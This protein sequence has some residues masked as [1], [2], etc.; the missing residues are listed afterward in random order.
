MKPYVI[1]H[2]MSSVDGHALTDGW[3]RTVKKQAD[4]TYERLAER[5]D[6]DAWACGRVT[7]EEIAHGEGYPKG[8]AQAP[9]PRTHHFAKR[10]ASKYAIAIDPQGKVAWKK[11]EALDSHVVAVL[12]EAVSDDYLAHLQSI[13]ASYVFGGKQELDLAAVLELLN[14]ELGI[15]RLVVEGGPHVSGSFVA[16]GLVDEISV[17]IIPLVDGR[18]AHPASFEIA[19]Q[20]WQQPLYLSLDSAEAQDDGSVWLRYRRA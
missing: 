19:E 9:I 15:E 7:M 13:G 6:F 17:L 12:S 18:G 1:C 16:A 5:F 8:V 4:T 20:V 2:M 3:D 14:T 11:N 10:D